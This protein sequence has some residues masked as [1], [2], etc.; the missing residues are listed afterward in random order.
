MPIQRFET[1]KTRSSHTE[2]ER[3][4]VS[5][6]RSRHCSPVSLILPP[7]S[8][9][10]CHPLPVPAVTSRFHGNSICV[11]VHRT[12][13]CP[14]ENDSSAPTCFSSRESRPRSRIFSPA[15]LPSALLILSLRF[16]SPIY[17]IEISI[18]LD[19][20]RRISTSYC[21]SREAKRN[22]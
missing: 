10:H 16:L 18:N 20:S 3:I 15:P 19:K 2:R 9:S 8:L 6:P 11:F 14:K 7:L 1:L 21:A 12:M 17:R 13:G 5:P 4:R 22:A